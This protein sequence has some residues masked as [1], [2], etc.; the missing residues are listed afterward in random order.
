MPSQQETQIE[1]SHILFAGLA[2]LAA[3]ASAG[4]A[5]FLPQ[6]GGHLCQRS[7]GRLDDRH[8]SRRSRD[9]L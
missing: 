5:A 3:T 6:W 9:P 1:L 8:P 4:V 2:D 7:P